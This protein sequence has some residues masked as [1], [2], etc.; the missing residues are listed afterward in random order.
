MDARDLYEPVN[1]LLCV[2]ATVKQGVLIGL[3]MFCLYGGAQ[4]T[5]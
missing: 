1:M 5:L 3:G 2:I 4:S